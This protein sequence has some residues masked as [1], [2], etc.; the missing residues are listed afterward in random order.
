MN[1]ILFLSLILILSIITIISMV[2]ISSQ[3][4][5]IRDDCIERCE[6]CSAR[7]IG[8]AANIS[9]DLNSLKVPE[10]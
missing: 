5:S 10:D 3:C 7:V 8:G 4:S 9:I 2:W 1:H 6:N